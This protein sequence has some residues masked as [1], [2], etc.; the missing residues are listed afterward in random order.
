MTSQTTDAPE[1]DACPTCHA[2]TTTE[3]QARATHDHSRATDYRI[4]LRRHLDTTHPAHRPT[5]L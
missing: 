5:R 1:P 4:L 2:L 3:R